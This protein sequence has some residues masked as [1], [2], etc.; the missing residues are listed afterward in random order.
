MMHVRGQESGT[1]AIP[2]EVVAMRRTAV[3]VITVGR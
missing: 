3:V 1:K 2:L